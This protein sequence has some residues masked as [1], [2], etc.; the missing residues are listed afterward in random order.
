MENRTQKQTEV[1]RK[2]LLKIIRKLEPIETT[3][4]IGDLYLQCDIYKSCKGVISK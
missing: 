2:Q 3:L 4:S 1:L